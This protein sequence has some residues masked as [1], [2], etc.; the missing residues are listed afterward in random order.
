MKV[1]VKSYVIRKLSQNEIKV[2][3]KIWQNESK[4]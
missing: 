4:S 3:I 2:K 1:K